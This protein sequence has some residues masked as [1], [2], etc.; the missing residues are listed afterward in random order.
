MTAMT[1]EQV[2]LL[3]AASS[4]LILLLFSGA[5]TFTATVLARRHEAQER[6]LRKELCVAVKLQSV[7]GPTEPVL[8]PASLDDIVLI[9]AQEEK[10]LAPPAPIP[11]ICKICGLDTT[12]NPA[13]WSAPG[14]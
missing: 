6:A 13:H 8:L 14:H 5:I 12:K 7:G 10:R 4:E 11:D 1:W 9:R 2:L 3:F